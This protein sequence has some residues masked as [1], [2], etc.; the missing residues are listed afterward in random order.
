[1]SKIIESDQNEY[2]YNVSNQDEIP[3]AGETKKTID[4]NLLNSFLHSFPEDKKDQSDYLKK[5]IRNNPELIDV[6]RTLV[7]ISDKRMYLELSFVF[8]KRLMKGSDVSL[9]GDTLYNLNKHPLKFFKSRI[10][11]GDRETSLNSAEL[12]SNYL[13][14]RDLLRVLN[15][16]TQIS[17]SG[18]NV[19]IDK[20]IITKEIQQEQ[21]KRRGHGAEF[22][23][24]KH[25]HKLGCKFIPE[26]RYLKPMGTRDPNVGRKDFQ[27]AKKEKGK[28][29]SF[30]LI[31][32]DD[33]NN[34]RIFIQGLI[35]TSDPGQYGVNK[36]DETVSIKDTLDKYNKENNDNKE[37][38]GLVDGVGFCENKKD[39]INKMLY[40]FDNFIQLKSLYKA[41]LRLHKLRLV[42]IKGIR[43]DNTFYNLDDITALFK[44]YGS[45]DIKLIITKEEGLTL[46]REIEAGK[47]WLYV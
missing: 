25:L 3:I 28:T 46:G 19:I 14:D 20:L 22:E 26:D 33:E 30:D 38:W 21:A 39:T 6:L 10:S 44:K 27:I 23:L 8:S 12:I 15:S 36:S 5:G 2:W 29:W 16:L 37:L 31:I 1:M 32:T 35:H 18:L 9:S 40:E 4:V 47:A 7:G 45:E 42:N 17:A 41:G 11:S 13:I 43:F 24:A 34:H